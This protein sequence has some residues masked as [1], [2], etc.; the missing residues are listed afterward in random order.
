[1][2][3]TGAPRILVVEN[4]PGSTIDRFGRWWREDGLEVHVVRAHSE[5]LPELDGYD[6]LVL[7]G[8][9]FMPTDD[10]GASWLPRERA[11][12]LEALGS[13]LPFLGIC[14]G[15]QLLAVVGDGEVE[16]KSGRPENGSTP[17]D[18]LPSA[19]DDPLFRG[20]PPIVSVIENHEDTITKLPYGAILLASTERCV[21]Q[22]FR[23]GESAWGVQ[24][25]PEASA[26][27]VERWDHERLLA[28]GIDSDE[29]V[30]RAAE[31]ERESGP[32]WRGFAARFA[33]IVAAGR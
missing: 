32:I 25:H 31:D 29:L 30:R 10:D 7:L 19:D 24:F 17:I 23:L 33:E 5:F 3:N 21:N 20:M 2:D 13:G 1:M 16:A 22:A 4:S 28:I 12:T 27:R 18:I 8:G 26:D 15:G 14:L 11:L 9:G 6:A